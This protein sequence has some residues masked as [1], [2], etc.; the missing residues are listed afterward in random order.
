M[1]MYLTTFA[2]LNTRIVMFRWAKLSRP[3][4]VVVVVVIRRNTRGEVGKESEPGGTEGGTRD[5]SRIINGSDVV[6][7]VIFTANSKLPIREGG[8]FDGFSR[9][10]CRSLAGTDDSI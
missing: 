5:T 3:T 4:V 8:Y 1:D 6:R 9:S 2:G 10:C 7:T